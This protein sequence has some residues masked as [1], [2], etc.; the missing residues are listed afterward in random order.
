MYYILFDKET[1]KVIN[2]ETKEILNRPNGCE[3]VEYY[4]E[5]PKNDYLTVVNEREETK[6]FVEK[7]TVLKTV[8]EKE[9]QTQ[10]KLVY[11]EIEVK[12]ENGQIVFDEYGN[13]VLTAIPK[14]AE[15]AIEVDVEKEVEE[16]IEEIKTRTYFTCDLIANF[17]PSKTDD[18]IAAEKRKKYEDLIKALIR[19]KYSQDDVEAIFANYLSIKVEEED[20]IKFNQFQEYREECKKLANKEVYGD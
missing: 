7:R 18:Q 10:N 20:I 15:E 2:K 11:E 12:D 3:I 14:W 9:P 4:G 6:T 17:Y 13:K 19:K 16:E 1:K 5:I 8:I